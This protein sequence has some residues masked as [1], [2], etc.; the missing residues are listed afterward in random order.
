MLRSTV[1]HLAVVLVTVFSIVQTARA[2]GSVTFLSAGQD[3][4]LPIPDGHCRLDP[5]HPADRKMY[6]YFGNAKGIPVEMVT[7]FADCRE[8]KKWRTGKKKLLDHYGYV[9][10]PKAKK[11]R[12]IPLSQQQFNAILEKS[13]AKTSDKTIESYLNEGLD[14]AKAALKET[15]GEDVSFDQQQMLGQLGMDENGY[16]GGMRIKARTPWGAKVAIG[17]FSM[18]VVKQRVLMIYLY[19]KYNGK[20]VELDVLLAESK[21]ASAAVR[22]TNP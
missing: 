5:S 19:D 14:T 17:V 20:P 13:F 7:V 12:V 1:I 11:D 10:L 15:T 3:L 21:R 22:A 18:T 6:E 2:G 9:G 4:T 16:Y 8:L